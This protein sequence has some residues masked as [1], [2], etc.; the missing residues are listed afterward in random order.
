MIQQSIKIGRT[1]SCFFTK[2]QKSKLEA[3]IDI[4]KEV[5]GSKQFVEQILQFEWSNQQQRR[6]H[7]FYHASGLSNRQVL[8]RIKDHQG[9]FNELGYNEQLVIMPFNSR[10]EIQSYKSV[11][12]PIIWISMNCIQNN[13]YTP[14]HIASAIGHE[15]AVLLGLDSSIHQVSR[16]E[17]QMYKVPDSIGQ[18]IMKIAAQ[19]RAKISD[20]ESA[21]LQIDENEYNYFP[22]STVVGS[23]NAKV[24][25]H[26]QTNFDN[27]I[28]SLL[29][30]QEALFALQE[31]LTVSE[32]ARLICIEEVLLKLKDLKNQLVECSLDGSELDF[33]KKV[34]SLG[35]RRSN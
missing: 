21:F 14:I 24:S 10:R 31:D 15:L 22:A 23:V 16:P 34:P 4:L 28:S 35:S 29:I 27:L 8:D 3:G 2:T 26:S 1:V 6:F 9:Y 32:T 11:N 5:L 20:I 12:N 19:W 30:E 33:Q 7:R 25:Q 18:M 13:W 17:Y